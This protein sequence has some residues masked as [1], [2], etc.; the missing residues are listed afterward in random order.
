MWEN[1]VGGVWFFKKDMILDLGVL[2][3]GGVC[4]FMLEVV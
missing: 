2:L 1:F 4:C 3:W